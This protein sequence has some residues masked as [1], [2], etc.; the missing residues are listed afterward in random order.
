MAPRFEERWTGLPGWLRQPLAVTCGAQLTSLPWSLPAFRL[1]SPLAP[2]WN[3]VA[4][5]WTALALAG[6]LAWVAAAM[7]WPSCALRLAPLLDLAAWPFAAVAELSPRLS[8][9][10]ICAWG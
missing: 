9:P 6:S 1:L 10:R 2:C 8:R 7:I 4:V 5:P 3:L